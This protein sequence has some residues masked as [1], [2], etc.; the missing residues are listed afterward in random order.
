MSAAHFWLST[1]PLVDIVTFYILTFDISIFRHCDFDITTVDILT[2]NHVWRTE[3]HQFASAISHFF[4][5]IHNDEK[6]ECYECYVRNIM[7]KFRRNEILLKRNRR[8]RQS[9]SAASPAVNFVVKSTILV[10]PYEI[11]WRNLDGIPL[12]WASNAGGAWKSRFSTNI[13]LYLGND[14]RHCRSCCRMP[15]GSRMRS[16]EQ[17]RSLRRAVVTTAD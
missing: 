11:L 15:I 10:F 12:T 8:Q 13:S 3:R 16:I 2:V 17:Y 14:T 6:D 4:S 5:S 1:F 9:I 7:A